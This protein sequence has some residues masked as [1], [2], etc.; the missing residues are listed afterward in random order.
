MIKI[1]QSSNGN[2][3][4]TE[5]SNILSKCNSVKEQGYSNLCSNLL[6]SAISFNIPALQFPNKIINNPYFLCLYPIN[7]L[8]LSNQYTVNQSVQHCF[9][10]FCNSSITPDFPHEHLHISLRSMRAFAIQPAK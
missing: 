4:Y 5:Q 2:N 7:F 8:R 6:F 1:F 9:V 10:K 3:Q